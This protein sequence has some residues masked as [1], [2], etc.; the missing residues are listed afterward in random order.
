MDTIHATTSGSAT[1]G[2]SAMPRPLA[3]PAT[4]R[5]LPQ[6]AIVGPTATEPR[7]PARLDTVSALNVL[8]RV[9]T[10][11]TIGAVLFV[12]SSFEVPYF[13]TPPKERT[14]VR[15]DQIY[16]AVAHHVREALASDVAGATKAPCASGRSDLTVRC[17]L[18]RYQVDRNP[19]ND[20]QPAL[21]AAAPE[22]CQVAMSI[23]SAGEVR[24]SQQ[25]AAES[26][27][28]SYVIRTN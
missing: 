3:E 12:L 20:L 24:L 26:S 13:I 11:V 27:F 1:S 17:V 6:A 10:W 15:C 4:R 21:V 28:R 16:A 22:S 8:E 14:S 23:D 25:P 2:A 18:D 9:G 19:R 5:E 7:T